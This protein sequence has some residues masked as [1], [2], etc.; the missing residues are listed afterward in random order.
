MCVYYSTLSTIIIIQCRQYF[1][2]SDSLQHI[3]Y[4]DDG[5]FSC[6]SEHVFLSRSRV[7][8]WFGPTTMRGNTWMKKK[9]RQSWKQKMWNS[10]KYKHILIKHLCNKKLLCHQISAAFILDAASILQTWFYGFY[11]SSHCN[12]SMEMIKHFGVSKNRETIHTYSSCIDVWILNK[13]AHIHTSLQ[14]LSFAAINCVRQ[15]IKK[16]AAH[17]SQWTNEWNV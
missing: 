5:A 11:S 6:A 4:D 14:F 1:T 7:I 8:N 10:E 17:K 3:A 15:A 16:R 2:W 12:R 13:F 9:E